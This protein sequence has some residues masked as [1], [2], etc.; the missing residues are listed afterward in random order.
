MRV[1][2]F[3]VGGLLLAAGAT[4][5]VLADQEREAAVAQAKAS[6]ADQQE[7][8]DAAVDANR[9]LGGVLDALQATIAQ[10]SEQLADTDGF[11][12]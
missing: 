1:L 12:E 7:R 5:V 9:S 10:Q 2:A 8:L 6:L 11:L 3:V 4:A